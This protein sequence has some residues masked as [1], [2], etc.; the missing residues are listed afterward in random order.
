MNR[1]WAALLLSASILSLA[2]CGVLQGGLQNV[3]LPG[4]ADTG[5]DPYQ[6]TAEFFDV[7]ELVPQSL[8]KVNDVSV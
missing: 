4:G 6:V 2:G 5:A 1:W 8:V 7:L 3:P